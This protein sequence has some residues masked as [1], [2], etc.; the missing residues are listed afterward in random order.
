[1]SDDQRPQAIEVRGARVHN[2]KNIDIPLGELV[3]VAGVSGSVQ[4]LSGARRAVCV[5]VRGR[6]LEA[7]STY[8]RRRLT[9]TSR[10]QVDEVPC[11]GRAG[12][13]QRPTSPASV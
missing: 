8:T 10:A 12:L 4:K 9:Q 11:A 7:L 3:G 1:M 5:A 13:H 2:L 6:Y